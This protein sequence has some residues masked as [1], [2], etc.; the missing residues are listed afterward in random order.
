MAQRYIGVENINITINELKRAPSTLPSRNSKLALLLGDVDVTSLLNKYRKKN[1]KIAVKS[2]DL[3][4]VGIQTKRQFHLGRLTF[5][6]QSR[7]LSHIF[8]INNVDEDKCIT[9]HFNEEIKMIMHSLMY[10]EIV[11]EKASVEAVMFC[12]NISERVEG[13][14]EPMWKR[15]TLLRALG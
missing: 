7:S 15:L 13:D 1:I 9:K 10:G 5:L 14:F 2:N 8:P 11:L 3:S 12:K 4:D 6:L